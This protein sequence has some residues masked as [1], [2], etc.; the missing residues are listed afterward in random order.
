MKIKEG[1]FFIAVVLIST[2]VQA[3]PGD[4][5]GGGKP[6]VPIPGLEILVAGGAAYGFRK[7]IRSRKSNQQ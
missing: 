1:L 3:Q 7:L 2:T 4:P 5:N 6:G